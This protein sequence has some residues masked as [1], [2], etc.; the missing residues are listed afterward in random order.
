MTFEKKNEKGIRVVE[1]QPWRRVNVNF[2]FSRGKVLA[3]LGKDVYLVCC[4]MDLIYC[5]K[6]KIRK[7]LFWIIRIF[8]ANYGLNF[9][10]NVSIPIYFAIYLSWVYS[11]SLCYS[12]TSLQINNNSTLGGFFERNHS[13]WYC[14]LLTTFV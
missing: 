14:M 12:S 10:A 3:T 13:P 4:V 5:M 11:N 7:N 1:M 8:F 9:R 2:V 6:N